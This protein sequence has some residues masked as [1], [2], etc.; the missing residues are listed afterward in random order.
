MSATLPNLKEIAVWVDSSLYVT[1]FRPVIVKEYL[2]VGLD[3]LP[4]GHDS[5]TVK[6]SAAKKIPGDRIGL[7][8]LLEQTLGENG[9]VLVF[10]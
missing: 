4:F 3:L 8:P 7:Y 9:S 10:C 2:K 5:P 1:H 6:L